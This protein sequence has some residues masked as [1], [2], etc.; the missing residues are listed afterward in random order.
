MH[1]APKFSVSQ[2]QARTQYTAVPAHSEINPAAETVSYVSG[3]SRFC[4]HSY[5]SSPN[6]SHGCGARIVPLPQHMS[7][8]GQ[9]FSHPQQMRSGFL[10]CSGNLAIWVSLGR[11]KT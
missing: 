7:S 9:S 3:H 2:V 1:R 11:V 6:S 8:A 5:Q 4:S 10:G